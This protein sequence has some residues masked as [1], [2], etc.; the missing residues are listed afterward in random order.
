MGFFVPSIP[1]RLRF[2]GLR[3]CFNCP[4]LSDLNS[5]LTICLLFLPPSLS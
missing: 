2:G 1:F 3:L 5:S 4:R